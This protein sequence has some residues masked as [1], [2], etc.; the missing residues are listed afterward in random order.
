MI[1]ETFR[2]VKGTDSFPQR[3]VP[4]L[5]H[6][7]SSSEGYELFPDVTG[8]FQNVRKSTIWEN[9]SVGV[10]SNSD[11]RVP[12]ILSSLGLKLSSLR[13][14]ETATLQTAAPPKDEDIDF[15]VLSYDVGHEKPDRQIFDAAKRLSQ[16][17]VRDNKST[18]FVH[19]GDDEKKDILAAEKA[20]W[21]AI[22]VGGFGR[23]SS[24]ISDHGVFV[25]DLRDVMAKLNPGQ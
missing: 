25:E 22:H 16:L 5:L 6:R 2:S 9:V 11:D 20:G 3:L 10:I 19:V 24:S 1:K 7:F 23:S 8:F 21:K 4:D 18:V 14:S 17:S 15:V 13:Y 12:N